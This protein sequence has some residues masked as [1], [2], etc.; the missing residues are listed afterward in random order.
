[1]TQQLDPIKLLGELKQAQDGESNAAELKHVCNI[2]VRNQLF[3]AS[4]KEIVNKSHYADHQ[5][6]GMLVIEMALVFGYKQGLI[7]T[8]NRG[9]FILT[10]KGWSLGN[11]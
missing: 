6:Y 3:S 2:F 10:E 11:Y 8:I 9:S 5:E 4:L 1:M 7:D